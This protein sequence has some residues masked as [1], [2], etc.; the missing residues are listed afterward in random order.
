MGR[1]RVEEIFAAVKSLP[2]DR[3]RSE[4]ARLCEGDAALEVRC[5]RLLEFAEDARARES[6]RAAQRI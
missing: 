5:L 4:L 1:M 6:L 3:R 2:L